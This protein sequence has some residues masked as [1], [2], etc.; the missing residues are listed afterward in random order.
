[1]KLVDRFEEIVREQFSEKLFCIEHQAHRTKSNQRIQN[2]RMQSKT[3]LG[4][5]VGAG[6]LT[7]S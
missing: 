7:I 6:I 5:A 1:M 2:K 3:L 4:Q